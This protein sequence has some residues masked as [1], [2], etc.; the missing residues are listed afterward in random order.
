MEYIED[1]TQEEKKRVI[2]KFLRGE[3]LEDNDI[4]K[5]VSK[6]DKFIVKII[7]W[8]MLFND[9]DECLFDN[10]ENATEE[11]YLQ[12]SKVMIER[13]AY[14][15]EHR[16]RGR[17]EEIVTYMNKRGIIERFFLSKAT[18]EDNIDWIEKFSKL[19]KH[20]VKLIQVIEFVDNGSNKNN[21]SD[22][23]WCELAKSI[24]ELLLK[25]IS[26]QCEYVAKLRRREEEIVTIINKREIIERLFLGNPT[27]EDEVAW[28]EKFSKLDIVVV[29]FTQSVELLD[30][31]NRNDNISD[32]QRREVAKCA[33]EML[34]KSIVDQCEY[35]A[36]LHRKIRGNPEGYSYI[37]FM[38]NIGHGEICTEESMDERAK[39]KDRVT[40]SYFTFCKDSM[41]KL[42]DELEG[43]SSGDEDHSCEKAVRL[44]TNAV[45]EDAF[46]AMYDD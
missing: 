8:K 43:N 33:A 46:R 12:L 19:D 37:N 36:K 41:R 44:I 40:L 14:I 39:F 25:S 35:V 21:I 18:E 20:I 15:A 32:D 34:S 16:I 2:E 26:E 29:R 4:W 3:K 45:G 38:N 5:R 7:M 1:F 31:G 6:V 10:V 28:E 17:E 11:A 23:R 22:D 27:E 30:D 9:K 42:W 13:C 24:S